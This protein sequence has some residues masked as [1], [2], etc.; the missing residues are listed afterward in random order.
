[1]NILVTGKTDFKYNRTF[2]L[3]EGLRQLPE[4][5]L[6]EMRI[7]SKS[8]F[9]KEAFKREAE[10]SDFIYIPPFRHSDVKFIRN[11]TNK[12]IVFD[13][14]ISEYLTKVVDYGH[15]WKAPLKYWNDYRAFHKC[16][17]LISDTEHHKQYFAKTFHIAPEKIHTVPVGLLSSLF[18]PLP[19]TERNDGKFRVGFYGTLVPLQGGSKIIEAARI[20]QKHEHIVFEM[21]GPGKDVPGLIR[22]YNLKNVHLPGWIAYEKLNDYLNT[23][24]LCL[25]IFGDSLKADLVIPNK[26][27]HYAGLKKCIVTKDTPGIREIF[28]DQ[29]NIVLTSNRPEDIAETILSLTQEPEKIKRIGENAYNLIAGNYNEV[30][31]AKRLVGILKG[32][33]K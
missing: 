13:P 28:T 3:L 23:F 22:K 20:L 31:I 17:I 7:H 11:L 12:P 21:I 24:D 25:G 26:V 30:E 8:K 14:L 29:E 33:G 2:T 4:V 16:D 19:Q 5:Q 27:Y 1:M 32:Y 15:F 6:T 9:D 10:K 18:K